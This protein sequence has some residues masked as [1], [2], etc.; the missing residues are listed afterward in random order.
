MS[1][2]LGVHIQYHVMLSLTIAVVDWILA[3][4]SGLQVQSVLPQIS[5]LQAIICRG[6]PKNEV[7][8]EVVMGGFEVQSSGGMRGARTF[9]SSTVEGSPAQSVVTLTQSQSFNS[10]STAQAGEVLQCSQCALPRVSPLVGAQWIFEG[11]N[12]LPCPAYGGSIAGN[13]EFTVCKCG[14]AVN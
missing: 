4:Y 9:V 2:L 10:V 13:L 7:R 6:R 8:N 3:Y 11:A 5:V 1:Q 12:T 14:L